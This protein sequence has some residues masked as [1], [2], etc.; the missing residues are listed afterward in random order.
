MEM[1]FVLIAKF[2]IAILLAAISAYT[3]IFLFDRATGDIDEWAELR[4]GNAAVGVTLGALVIALAIIL[5]S[6]LRA[7]G[8]PEDLQPGLYPLYALVELLIRFAIGF[9]AGLVGVLTGIAL[10]DRMTGSLD[11]FAE[12]K[13][14][15]MGVAI[16]LAA[17]IIATALLIAPV[18]NIAAQFVSEL[19]FG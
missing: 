2:I 8:V 4:A 15:N 5:Q 14:G 17:V 7:P 12:I 19:L 9:V 10:Y 13:K 1:V 3:G 18:V 16:T 6:S 11:E